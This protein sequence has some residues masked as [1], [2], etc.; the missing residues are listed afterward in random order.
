MKG[1]KNLEYSR[2]EEVNK[3]LCPVELERKTK[4][5]KVIKNKYN[6][7]NQRILAFRELYP[8]G[9]IQTEIIGLSDGVVTIKAICFDDDGKIIST[10]HAQEKEKSSFINETS[11]IEN[12][13][14]SAIGRA[15]G[16]IGIGAVDSLATFEEVANA[17]TNQQKNENAEAMIAEL[18]ELYDKAGGKDFDKWA[19]DCGGVS[20]ETFP[21]MKAKLMKQI[22][23]KAE[24]I[25][26]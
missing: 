14:T 25:K 24:E 2:I 9:S 26:K 8:N 16:V 1:E 10:G 11:F 18:K 19:S 7:V 13:E 20:A 6:T 3:R 17:I 21:K 12:C 15:L 4:T 23:D 22:N 5:G